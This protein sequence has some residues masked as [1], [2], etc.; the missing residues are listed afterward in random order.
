[1]ERP[2]VVRLSVSEEKGEIRLGVRKG[3]A[4]LIAELCLELSEGV[5]IT[6]LF[7]KEKE[8]RKGIGTMLLQ[9]ALSI[10]SRSGGFVPVQASF[11]ADESEDLAEFFEAQPNF[12]VREE[13]EIY[14]IKAADRKKNSRWKEL[15][16]GGPGVVE[17]F[18]LD[19]KQQTDFFKSVSEEGFEGFVDAED[20]LLEKSMC[21]ASVKDGK[22]GGAV[23]FRKHGK[24]ELELSFL[25]TEVRNALTVGEL[26][27]H[28]CKVADELYP[29]ADI[30]FSAVTPEAAGMADGF[31]GGKA[32]GERVCTALWNG[33]SVEELEDFGEMI[34]Q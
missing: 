23:F 4:G 33:W 14:T 30:W 10:I 3:K 26:L 7:V 15:K 29:D 21:L 19:A 1:M 25:F 20:P 31:F 32:V 2:E 13:K 24:K 6:Y 16:K 17:F 28:A 8:R 34:A 9:N 22:A 18:S 12:T 27:G 5:N 11:L